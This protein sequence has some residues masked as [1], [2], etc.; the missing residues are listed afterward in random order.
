MMK[1]GV[2][3]ATP[4]VSALAA[5]D[6]KRMTVILWHYHDDDLPGPAAAVEVAV[7]NLP[8]GAAGPTLRQYRIDHDHSNSFTAWQKMGSPQKP[9]AEQYAQLERAGQ[10]AEVTDGATL[11]TETRGPVIR[12]SLPRQAVSL[13][14][15]E[16]K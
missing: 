4:D 5:I 6:G 14:V 10:L 13:L 11:T 8:P 12:L 9:T 3:G 15:I 1:G 16:W 2:R 7:A